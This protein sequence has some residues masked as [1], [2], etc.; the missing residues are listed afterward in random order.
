MNTI[1]LLLLFLAL[2]VA[3]CALR[4]PGHAPGSGAPSYGPAGA[5]PPALTA[6]ADA[7]T[8]PM[9]QWQRTQWPDGRVVA[10]TVP[11]RY[12]L[13][14]EAG[15]R[16]LLRADCNRGSGSYQVDG[17]ALVLGPAATTRMACP[18]DSQ[19]D[20]FLRQLARTATYAIAGD[21]LAVTLADGGT[22]RFRRAP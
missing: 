15:G 13:K 6:A 14:F 9:W 22:M 21:E 18:S 5:S 10:A 19:D 11:E 16:V 12:T 2:A 1:R 20:A 3:G 7:L 4:D 17:N 8:G